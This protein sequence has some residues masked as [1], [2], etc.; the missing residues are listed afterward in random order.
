MRWFA[1]YITLNGSE[2]IWYSIKS[3]YNFI[4]A[5]GGK[6]VIIEGS[7]KF[8]TNAAN[9]GN[10]K[11][12]TKDIIT[13]FVGDSDPGFIIYKRVGRVEDKRALRNAY[14]K[15][16]RSLPKNQQPDWILMVDDDE[17]YKREDLERL[18]NYLTHHKDVWYIYNDQV[19]FWGDFKHIYGN[20][21]KTMHKL[22]QEGKRSELVYYDMNGRKTRQGEFHERIFKWRTD[23]NYNLS[24]ATV[25]DGKGRELYIHPDYQ[26][27]R[28]YYPSC[29]RYHY[30]YMTTSEKMAA[31]FKYYEQRDKSRTLS[32]A[33][34]MTVWN[35]NYGWFLLYG[36]P[37]NILTK[38]SEFN[39]MQPG[40][41]KEHPYYQKGKCPMMEEAEKLKSQKGFS[42]VIDSYD[43][44]GKLRILYRQ[45]Y[46]LISNRL[47]PKST[48]LDV[49]GLGKFGKRLVQEGHR[50]T[51]LNDYPTNMRAKDPGVTFRYGPGLLFKPHFKLKEFDY[52]H[53]FK[54]IKSLNDH[55]QQE[56]IKRFHMLLKD[57]G[58]LFGSV[59]KEESYK[60]KLIALLT[61]TGFKGIEVREIPDVDKDDEPSVYWY[62]A[63][64]QSFSWMYDAFDGNG[65]LII[66]YKYEYALARLKPASKVLDV[67]GRGKFG[68]RLI[69]EGHQCVVLNRNPSKI[70]TKDKNIRF[71]DDEKL[72][73]KPFTS[74][75]IQPGS[76]DYIHFNRNLKSMTN[77]DQER[78]LGTFHTLLKK[79]GALFGEVALDPDFKGRLLT[80][81]KKAGFTN[82]E[83]NEIA[84]VEKGDTPNVYWYWGLKR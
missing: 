46:V 79:G 19:M 21:E 73:F 17:L 64:K 8:A 18:D 60:G 25:A 83:A 1:C 71:R 11:D 66:P 51:V 14:L 2:Y 5:S 74:K 67:D 50:C 42:W 69:Q 77:Q 27:H 35:D 22:I 7:T 31:R 6:I 39:G 23:L 59:P 56:Y 45:E 16:I 13:R 29:P 36:K 54:N 76:S 20:D 34:R 62:W 47:K 43:E 58:A 75:Q 80:I 65:K 38:I 68:K 41:M 82:L 15:A 3:I 53:C 48:I 10:S 81:L 32:E 33:E 55:E 40:I 12:E 63:V 28:V 78:Y 70:T 24:H 4:H 26:K 52:I 49:Q 57:G 61:H 72:L 30:G 84:D 9:D 44:N 37:K